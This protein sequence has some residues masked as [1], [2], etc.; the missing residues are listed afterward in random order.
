MTEIK[1]HLQDLAD[2]GSIPQKHIL[3]LEKLKRDGVNP[4]VI[5]DIG[6]N[7]LHWTKEVKR[8]WPNSEIILF[9]GYEKV[10]F[11]Y[12][13]HK[14]FIEVLSNENGKKVNF[15]QN[16]T[17]PGGNSYY[18]EIGTPS[19]KE[20]F[21]EYQERTTRTLD[22]LVG[23]YNL[24]LPDLVKIDVQGSEQDVIKGGMKTLKHCEHLIVELQKKEYNLGAPLAKEMIPWLYSQGFIMKR[25]L[26]C[27]NGPD[28]DYHFT[29]ETS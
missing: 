16:D 5:Y 18:R 8:I 28:G 9:D 2:T 24:P 21:N 27:S 19:S 20:L 14:Y 6:A 11:L 10:K 12:Q 23:V 17:H 22:Y 25:V 7:V 1:K 15:Y 13:D 3:Y 4:M 29:R 26:F